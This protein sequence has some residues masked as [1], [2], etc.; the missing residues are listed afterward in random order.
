MA[1]LTDEEIDRLMA[2]GQRAVPIEVAPDSTALFPDAAPGETVG[3]ITGI[4]NQPQAQVQAQVQ[5]QQLS[6][7]DIAQLMGAGASQVQPVKQPQA[8]NPEL[9]EISSF[10]AGILSVGKGLDDVQRGLRIPLNE[11]GF[12]EGDIEEAEQL[13][14][15]GR[16]SEIAFKALK[17]KFPKSSFIGNVIG[18]TAPFFLLP[19]AAPVGIIA[20]LAA[21][22]GFGALEAGVVKTGQGASAVEIAGSTVLGAI[23]GTAVSGAAQIMEPMA[24]KAFN[25]IKKRLPKNKQGAKFFNEDGTPTAAGQQAIR[26]GFTKDELTDIIAKATPKEIDELA[27][28]APDVAARTLRARQSLGTPTTGGQASGDLLARREEEALRNIPQNPRATEAA[29]IR[30]EQIQ[31]IERARLKFLEPLKTG[32][33]PSRTGRGTTIKKAVDELNTTAKDNVTQLYKELEAIPGGGIPL[34]SVN[35]SSQFRVLADERA[36]S[37]PFVNK[38][39]KMLAG[40]GIV[41]PLVERTAANTPK[42]VTPLTFG[43]AHKVAKKLNKL[44]SS[45]DAQNALLQDFKKSFDDN[46]LSALDKAAN[47]QQGLVIREAANRA[48]DAAKRRFQTFKNKDIVEDLIEFKGFGTTD[49]IDNSKVLDK[50]LGSGNRVEQIIRVRNVLTKNPTPA[51]TNAWKEIQGQAFEDLF[52]GVFRTKN[53]QTILDGEAFGNNINSIG[54][55]AMKE[56]FQG[57]KVAIDKMAKAMADVTHVIPRTGEV[58]GLLKNVFSLGGLILARTGTNNLALLSRASGAGADIGEGLAQTSR[59]KKVLKAIKSGKPLTSNE[60]EQLFRE[61]ADRLQRATFVAGGLLGERGAD[62]LIGEL[63]Q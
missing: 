44:F 53:G 37:E 24:K 15:E 28:L 57:Q 14:R 54:D 5:P 21:G 29:E 62:A 7:D 17:E 48:R 49:R 27:E 40:F 43:N 16:T 13:R 41:D 47:G 9:D 18:E 61:F 55:D 36:V 4:D 52:D 22:A 63:Q 39:E 45:D 51:S 34:P 59:Q 3:Q 46:L 25:A 12:F 8:I 1:Q 19:I 23:F 6:N 20:R 38:V 60:S 11:L 30:G 50:I 2:G 56:L 35:L 33:D 10:Q 42:L 31:D 26:K 58:S 32:L